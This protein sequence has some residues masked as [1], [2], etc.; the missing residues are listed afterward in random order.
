MTYFEYKDRLFIAR[1][2]TLSRCFSWNPGKRF[3]RQG[4][5]MGRAHARHRHASPRLVIR[6]GDQ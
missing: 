1:G 4:G 6:V 2:S 5:G 3:G